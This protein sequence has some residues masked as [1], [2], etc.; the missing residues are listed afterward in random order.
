MHS[1]NNFNFNPPKKLYISETIDRFLL[2]SKFIFVD[3]NK[4]NDVKTRKGAS[5]D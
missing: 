5:C 4:E 3:K 2:I 1:I